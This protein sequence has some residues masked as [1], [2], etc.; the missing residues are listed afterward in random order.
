MLLSAAGMFF[1]YR[2]ARAASMLRAVNIARFVKSG[3]LGVVRSDSL[4]ALH[5]RTSDAVADEQP[6]R[7]KRHLESVA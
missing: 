3:P 4:V 6:R 1:G 5:P 7:T 2:Q